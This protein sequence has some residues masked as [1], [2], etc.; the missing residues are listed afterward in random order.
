M[1]VYIAR[2]AAAKNLIFREGGDIPSFLQ[3]SAPFPSRSS[4]PMLHTR[5]PLTSYSY[6]ESITYRASHTLFLD[7]LLE[8]T[9]YYINWVDVSKDTDHFLGTPISTDPVP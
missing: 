2:N 6:H 9:A 4:L 5:F 3:N 7:L 1:Y 8:P